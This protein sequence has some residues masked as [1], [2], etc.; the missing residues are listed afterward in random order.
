MILLCPFSS[1]S[2]SLAS[3]YSLF[4]YPSLL[5]PFLLPTC[6]LLFYSSFSLASPSSFSFSSSSLSTYFFPLHISNLLLL[7]LFFLLSLISL[8]D[9][10]F[11]FPPPYPPLSPSLPPCSPLFSSPLFFWLNPFLSSTFSSCRHTVISSLLSDLLNYSL[12]HAVL[13][14]AMWLLLSSP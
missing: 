12:T 2:V 8:I 7:F 3:I 4:P 10:L 13:L 11:L 14:P 6:R 5:S 9:F 1:S